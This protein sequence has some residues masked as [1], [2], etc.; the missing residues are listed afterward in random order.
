MSTTNCAGCHPKTDLTGNMTGALMAGINKIEGFATSNLTPDSSSRIFGWT[1]NN[2]VRRFRAKKRLA[3]R[4]MPWKS[5]KY[6]TDLELKA[7][8]RY[9]QTVPAAIMP[10]VKE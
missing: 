10:E 5:F 8:Y 3:E 6:M 1:E 9:L 4:P 7:I 2:F